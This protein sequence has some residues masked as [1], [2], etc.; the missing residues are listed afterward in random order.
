MDDILFKILIQIYVRIL[1]IHLLKFKE[2]VW[3]QPKEM[4]LVSDVNNSFENIVLCY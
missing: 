4:I 3:Q 1:Y 2:I